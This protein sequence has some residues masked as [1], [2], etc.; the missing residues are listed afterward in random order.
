MFILIL[1]GLLSAMFSFRVHADL[2][3]MQAQADKMQ[4][5]LAAEAGIERVKLMLRE[6]RFDSSRW[7]HNPEEFHRIIVWSDGGDPTVWGKDEKLD[8]GTPAFRFSIVADDPTDDLHRIRLGM[9]DESAKLNLNLATEEQL[10]TLVTQVIEGNEEIDPK[11]IVDAILDWR[12][13]DAEPRGE[14]ADT[15][16]AYYESLDQP[17]RVRNGPFATVEELLLVKGI[18]PVLLYGEDY[19]R[20]GLLTPNEDDGDESFPPDNQDSQL[21]RGLYPYLTVTSYENNV[22]NDQRPRVS[23][24]ADSNTIRE[25]LEADFPDEPEIAEYL[26]TTARSQVARRGPGSRIE[27]QSRKKEGQPAGDQSRRPGEQGEPSAPD[28]DAGQAQSDN[29][30]EA[31]NSELDSRGGRKEGPRRQR[32]PNQPGSDQP[33]KGP[34]GDTNPESEDSQQPPDEQEGASGEA[35]DG[36]KSEGDRPTGPDQAEGRQEGDPRSGR[37]PTETDDAAGGLEPIRS[38]AGLLRP[39]TLPTG[40]EVPNPLRPEHLP[41]LMDRLTFES[42]TKQRLDGLININTAPPAVLRCL[43]E[44]SEEQIQAIVTRRGGLDAKM[45]ATTAWL[46]TEGVLELD[47]LDRI[48]RYITARGQQFTIESL[49]YADHK[50]MVTRLQVI[51]DLLGPVPRTV[52]YRDLSRIGGHFPIREEDKERIGVR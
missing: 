18:T 9:T 37:R 36:S 17:Y 43:P 7:Y 20:N 50:G 21:N 11:A 10:L 12:D 23:M 32:R 3:A 38:P 14:E 2:A 39:Y 26:A 1:L 45:K 48:A 28:P 31:E 46:V 13:A 51:V 27:K 41:V 47:T 8:E 35:D 24:K 52:Y 6:S 42:P 44:L 15:E 40:Q 33:S 49:G 22:S 5:R 25:Q 34:S 4:T 30:E 29:T 19:D 16:E